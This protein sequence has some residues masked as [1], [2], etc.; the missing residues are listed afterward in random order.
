MPRVCFQRPTSRWFAIQSAGVEATRD[1]NSDHAPGSHQYNSPK[2]WTC[3]CAGRAGSSYFMDSGTAVAKRMFSPGSAAVSPTAQTSELACRTNPPGI[4]SGNHACRTAH[5]VD[6][7]GRLE[8]PHRPRRVERPAMGVRRSRIRSINE[9]WR[10]ASSSREPSKHS[11]VCE[12]LL[13][14]ELDRHAAW[15]QAC[16][17]LRLDPGQ[18][19]VLTRFFSLP[20]SQGQSHRWQ[21]TC[22][23]SHK[24][25]H[26]NEIY[27]GCII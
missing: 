19:V 11:G 6:R 22:P 23:M 27:C 4:F 17:N 13:P 1:G 12:P 5:R 20:I 2:L 15:G 16:W 3:F 21:N 7:D 14:K 24:I 25:I 8:I 9:P 10:S 26:Q 18:Q